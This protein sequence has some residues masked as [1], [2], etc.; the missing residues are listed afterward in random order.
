MSNPWNGKAVLEAFWWNSANSGYSSWYT[1]L[2][3]LAPR[4]AA[5]GFDGIWTPPPCKGSGGSPD[6]G[7]TPF[8]Y[9]D[10]GQKNQKGIGTSFGSQDE[11]LRLVAVAHA[12]DLEVYPDIV[13][14]HCGGGNSKTYQCAGF[15]ATGRW[16]RSWYDFHANPAHEQLSGDWCPSPGNNFGDDFCYQDRC[17]D[18][19]HADPNCYA[20]AQARAWFVWFVLQTGV[21]GFRFDDVKGFPPEV[22]ADV[23]YNAMGSDNQYFCVGEY[24]SGTSDL[25]NW[26]G[27]TLNRSGTF[28]YPFRNALVGLVYSNG[29]FDVGSLP[30]LQQQNR[31]KTV[32]F[33]NNQDVCRGAYWDSSGDNMQDHTFSA[34]FNNFKLG[35]SID[36][37][38]WRTPLAYA[39]AITVDGSPQFFYDDLFQNYPATRASANADTLPTRPY[40]ENLVWCHQKLAFKGGD[41][42]VRYQSSQQ[43]LIIERGAR[44]IVAINNDGRAW[45]SAWIS[46]AFF[47]NTRLH[48]YSG[49]RPD[50]IWTNQDAWVE[51]AVPPLSYSV[52]GPA[53][54]TGG[55]DPSPRRTV[56]QFELDDDLGDSN[57]DPLCPRYG[58]K[59]IPTIFRTAGA[60]W[61]APN[62][63]VN[64]SIYSD[65]PQQVDF[66]VELAGAAAGTPAALAKSGQSAPNVPFA[67]TLAVGAEGRYLLL[68]KLSLAAAPP[69]RLYVKVDYIGP[70]TSVLF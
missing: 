54:I 27:A 11:F 22:V 47:P 20:R 4:L 62:S 59:A 12:N 44:A 69:A 14:D 51:I 57:P 45:H 58:G 23:L 31:T 7:Y 25:D 9:Y 33:I 63:E 40:I 21:D 35:P 29:Y 17:S 42:F 52:W 49:S 36:P 55:F 60:I 6:M 1:Y 16:P 5:F 34:N 39:V 56:Q 8:D 43:L 70:A 13:L 68:A 26:A 24:L 19:G 65:T 61:P 3:K 67:A 64:I 41:Y 18:S 50:D 53:G 32:P 46:T 15:A 66:Q 48:D 38:N 28:D 30:S 37:D 2:A 10:L